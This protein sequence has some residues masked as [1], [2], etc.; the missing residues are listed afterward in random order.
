MLSSC[1][2]WKGLWRSPPLHNRARPPWD[3][4]CHLRWCVTAT[5][6]HSIQRQGSIQPRWAPERAGL[7]EEPLFRVAHGA[8]G[9]HGSSDPGRPPEQAMETQR[10]C[11][12]TVLLGSLWGWGTGISRG[13]SVI[14]PFLTWPHLGDGS[15]A[16]LRYK[17][18]AVT[19][20][21][22]HEA[23]LAAQKRSQ[24]L[25]LQVEAKI[26]A[27]TSVYGISFNIICL[28]ISEWDDTRWLPS[29]F[30][31]QEAAASFLLL[32]SNSHAL[33]CA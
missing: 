7:E 19:L 5:G 18:F 1:G 2:H 33:K 25:I 28:I 29:Q 12:H 23:F 26:T 8:E 15:G 21:V 13:L 10:K 24:D 11:L 22:K 4:R 27:A 31:A 17:D 6:A 32:L 20:L 14:L 9:M 16:L 3:H 30:S